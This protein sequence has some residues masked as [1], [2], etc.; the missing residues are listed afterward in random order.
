MQVA[1]HAYQAGSTCN[2]AVPFLCSVRRPWFWPTR[3]SIDRW[4]FAPA[5][6]GRVSICYEKL[7]D[8]LQHRF[9]ADTGSSG[10]HASSDVLAGTAVPIALDHHMSVGV[11]SRDCTR[12]DHRQRLSMPGGKQKRWSSV[13]VRELH[14]DRRRRGRHCSDTERQQG[15]RSLLPFQS[16]LLSPDAPI[17]DR[18]VLARTA[19]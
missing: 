2:H 7:G 17:S 6:N 1:R 18:R 13:R 8:W 9:C 14:V 12:R 16:A 4:I 5:V 15:H 10:S 11:A 3:R 19:D